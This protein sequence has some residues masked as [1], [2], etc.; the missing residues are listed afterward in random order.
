MLTR[1]APYQHYGLGENKKPG[2][3]FCELDASSTLLQTGQ[4]VH[5]GLVKT[6]VLATE[7]SSDIQLRPENRCT[8]LPEYLSYENSNFDLW[9]PTRLWPIPQSFLQSKLLESSAIRQA[10]PW[11]MKCWEGVSSYSV[12][13]LDSRAAKSQAVLT[14][15]SFANSFLQLGH[16]IVTASCLFTAN[17]SK[18]G[19]KSS[20]ATHSAWTLLSCVPLSCQNVLQVRQTVYTIHSPS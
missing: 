8:R 6:K 15:A 7:Q 10:K 4:E 13:E 16:P 11:W 18:M 19:N 3:S 14:T 2:Q 9:H 1:T 20:K 17:T 5:C 12:T